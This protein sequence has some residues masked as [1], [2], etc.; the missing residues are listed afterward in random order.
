MA[1]HAQLASRSLSLFGCISL[2]VPAEGPSPACSNHHGLKV[3]IASKALR[4][5]AVVPRVVI[6]LLAVDR[7]SRNEGFQGLL[8]QRA[9][10]PL[11]VIAGL[12]L[13]RGVDSEQAHELRAELDGISV[14]HL[15]ARA[16]TR[17][18]KGV[19]VGLCVSRTSKDEGQQTKAPHRTAH[20]HCLVKKSPAGKNGAKVGRLAAAEAAFR[21]AMKTDGWL[22]EE[23]P[24]GDP[25]EG[26]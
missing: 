22:V 16:G 7:P 14:D 26:A 4:H 21:T 3:V 10:L 11:P 18:D 1:V 24:A 20:S 17:P 12:P 2:A 8:R 15:K 6:H 9:G 5:R 13:L 25:A 23:P 19:I